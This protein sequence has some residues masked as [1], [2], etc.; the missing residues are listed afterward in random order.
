[1]APARHADSEAHRRPAARSS[2]R[3]TSPDVYTNTEADN[4]P[5]AKERTRPG[6]DPSEKVYERVVDAYVGSTTTSGKLTLQYLLHLSL[7]EGWRVGGR[8]EIADRW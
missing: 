8:G 7:V 6:S 3:D 5:G 4:Y 1:M 2:H